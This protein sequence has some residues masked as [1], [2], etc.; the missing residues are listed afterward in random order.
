MELVTRELAGLRTEVELLKRKNAQLKIQLEQTV[1]KRNLLDGASNSS[2][3][4]LGDR[5]QAFEIRLSKNEKVQSALQK[6]V[7]SR[8]NELISQMNKG[9][10]KFNHQTHKK[11]SQAS[12]K[13]ILKKD[14]FIK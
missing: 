1:K 7:E 13:I 11:P 8:L 14:L 12:T 4:E 9:F 3:Q 5:L 10:A 6:T 2:L